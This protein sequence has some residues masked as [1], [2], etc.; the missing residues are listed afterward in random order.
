MNYSLVC[1]AV[2]AR[3]VALACTYVC[4]LLT[5]CGTPADAPGMQL[6]AADS[7]QLRNWVP[8]WL[9]GQI[10]LL[11]VTGGQP[12]GR[13]WGAKISNAALQ[14]ALE[15][16]LRATGIYAS[17]PGQGRF[18]MTV[19]LVALEQPPVGL[20]MKVAVTLAYTVVE[21]ASG[22]TVYQ[23]RLRS[24]HVAEFGEAM[25]DQNERLR[26]ASE[27]AVRKNVNSLVR[28]LVGLA[29]N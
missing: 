23:R 26:L 28:E 10:Q 7:L 12:T 3:P 27:A 21:Q 29:L 25:L 2:W 5:A 8:E 11:P 14:E 17:R 18:Q 19:Q 13:Y 16:S 20:D 4:A 24:I 6:S 22:I 9:R 15:E 1:Q